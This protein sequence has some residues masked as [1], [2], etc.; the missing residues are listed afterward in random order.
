MYVKKVEKVLLRKFTWSYTQSNKGIGEKLFVCK[1]FPVKSLHGLHTGE[2][3]FLG[4]E[5]GKGFTQKSYLDSG[6]THK[7]IH[8]R[9]AICM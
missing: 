4:I 6:P 9:K 2:T 8:R 1:G 5:C 3:P 7:G